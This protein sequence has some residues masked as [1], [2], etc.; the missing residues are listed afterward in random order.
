MLHGHVYGQSENFLSMLPS[1]I[2][3]KTLRFTLHYVLL[4]GAIIFV[5]I[6]EVKTESYLSKTLI[7]GNQKN[8]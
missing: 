5:M 3:V 4:Y 7:N 1:V 6:K 8:K 2:K